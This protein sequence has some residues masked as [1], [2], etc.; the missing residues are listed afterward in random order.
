[1]KRDVYVFIGV[2]G[3]GKSYYADYVAKKHNAVRL[4]FKD[5]LISMTY[6]LLGVP[7]SY[8]YELFKKSEYQVPGT[9]LKFT[10]REILQRLGTQVVRNTIDSDYWCKALIRKIDALP[11]GVPVAIADCR[12]L[13]E[14]LSLSNDKYNVKFYLT[15]FHSPRYDNWCQHDSERLAQLV[16]MTKE[17]LDTDAEP[18]VPGDPNV[19]ALKSEFYNYVLSN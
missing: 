2:I 6:T 17:A 16:L 7:E 3:S 12:F 14:V 15:N 13:N 5:A 9:D 4:D 11:E 10:G 19:C 8:D 1:M 18:L